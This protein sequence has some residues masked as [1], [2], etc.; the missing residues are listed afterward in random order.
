MDDDTEEMLDYLDAESKYDE[1]VAARHNRQLALADSDS[2][3]DEADQEYADEVLGMERP[4][5]E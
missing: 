2:D 4:E 3:I 1:C 5:Y